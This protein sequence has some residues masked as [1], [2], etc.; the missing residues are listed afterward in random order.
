MIPTTETLRQ[1]IRRPAWRMRPQRVRG[2]LILLVM[3]VAVPLVLFSVSLLIRNVDAQA[4]QTEQLVLD[5]T[6]LLAED[7]EREVNRQ[8]AAAEVLSTS[9]SLTTDDLAAFY[10][11]AIG[12]RDRLGTNVVLRDPQGRQRVNS[13]APWGRTSRTTPCSKPTSG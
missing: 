1:P 12:V 6:R 8:I 11:Q 10:R 7:V 4:Q 2:W 13:R 9:E 3:A 5:R